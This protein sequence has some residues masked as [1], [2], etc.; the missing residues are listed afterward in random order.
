MELGSVWAA[1]CT[2]LRK[3]YSGIDFM[4]VYFSVYL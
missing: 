3:A 2:D 4:H 1:D